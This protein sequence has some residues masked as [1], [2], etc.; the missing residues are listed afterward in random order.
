M[1][2]QVQVLSGASFLLVPREGKPLSTLGDG[3]MQP[4]DVTVCSD[5]RDLRLGPPVHAGGAMYMC[6]GLRLSRPPN[7]GDVLYIFYPE[8]L[9]RDA[10]WEAVWPSLVL[11]GSVGLA[12]LGLAVGLGKRLSRRLQDLERRTRLIAAG[13]FSPMPLPTRNDEIF[14]LICSVNE[15][16]QKLAQFQET[17]RR[18]ERLRLL[19]QV[20]G[21]LAI[22]LRNGVAGRGWRCSYSYGSHR[23]SGY[24][25]P[26]CGPASVDAAGNRI[27]S[28]PRPWPPGAFALGAVFTDGAGGRGGGALAA[29][30]PA[31]RHRP[32]VG[33]R[34]PKRRSYPATRANSPS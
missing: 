3:P 25:G 27:S 5:W 19:G 21:G 28:D 32:V 18:T 33:S 30:V 8:L 7:Q 23:P 29:A 14:D 6:S 31:R 16:A 10:L 1:L 22:R 12:S 4:P 13:D 11:G 34:P 15:M 20:G 17:A 9:L 2:E 26:G 24:G